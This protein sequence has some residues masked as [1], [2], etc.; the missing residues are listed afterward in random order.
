LNTILEQEGETLA[1][2]LFA[3]QQMSA[4]LGMDEAALARALQK[5]S[6]LEEIGGGELFNVAGAD[7]LE[8]AKALGATPDKIAELIKSED[9]RTTDEKM[10]QELELLTDSLINA[11]A[12]NQ[13][14][15]VEAARVAAMTGAGKTKLSHDLPPEA[16]GFASLSAVAVG[17]AEQI[18]SKLIS[19][20]TMEVSQMNVAS[21]DG[22]TP[23]R[24]AEGGTVPAGF[25]NDTYPALLT[26]GEA[27]IPP[28]HPLP[29]G[30][31]GALA[32]TML[33]VGAMIVAAIK[34]GGINLNERY[35]V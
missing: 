2:N 14:S 15:A 29:V 13:A 31:E 8:S 10:L 17:Q 9:T 4:L 7:L 19:A 12:P 23:G 26:S 28:G 27:V 32:N 34:S 11:I 16:M 3:R 25:P 30:N 22:A 21:G 18:G 33:Q 1:N 5:K 6:I 24:F 35:S 20:E